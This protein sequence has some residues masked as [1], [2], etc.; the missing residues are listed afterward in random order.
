MPATIKHV[1][2]TETQPENARAY[3][4]HRC[5]FVDYNPAAITAVAFP[6]LVLPN[7]HGSRRKHTKRMRKGRFGTLAV[8]RANGNIELYEWAI[9]PNEQQHTL[10]AL[11]AW[12]LSKVCSVFTTTL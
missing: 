12:V 2:Q 10:K 7:L 11:Q 8:G 5:R 4:V 9:P 1:S 6:P 3:A